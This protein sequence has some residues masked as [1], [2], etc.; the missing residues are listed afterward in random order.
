MPLY[1]YI[2]TF[3]GKSHISQ[4]RQSNFRGFID[5]W[6]DTATTAALGLPPDLKRILYKNMDRSDFVEVQNRKHVWRRV[7][8]LDGDDLVIYAV[9]TQT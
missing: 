4:D 6:T 7:I 5:A 3:K 1:T 2:A 9:Q 8:N